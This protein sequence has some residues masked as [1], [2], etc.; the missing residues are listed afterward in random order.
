VYRSLVNLGRGE[1]EVFWLTMIW[2]LNPISIYTSTIHGQFDSVAVMFSLLSWYAVYFWGEWRGA[3]LG[4]VALGFAVLDKTWPL[5]WV[6]PLAV[7][8]PAVR[9]RLAFLALVGTVPLLALGV[10]ELAIGTTLD[11]IQLRV[12]DYDAVPNRYGFTYAFGHYLENDVPS[13]WLP[14]FQEHARDIFLASI[15]V[16]SALVVPRRDAVTSCVAIFAA[17][18]VF[19]HGWGSQYL[20][21]VLPFAIIARQRHMLFVYTAVATTAVWVYYFGSCGYRCPGRFETTHQYWQFAWVWPVAMVWLARE[22]LGALAAGRRNDAPVVLAVQA[23][24]RRWPILRR[25]P[26]DTAR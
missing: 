17:F 26:A 1:S 20:V 12:V 6:A 21:W 7:V 4:G 2:A 11:L 22:V 10:Y 8:A 23:V 14:Y 19:A 3:L 9:H 5:M 25:A 16:V 18:L 13:S 15:I 24:R